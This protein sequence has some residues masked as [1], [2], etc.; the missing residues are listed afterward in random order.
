[1]LNQIANQ[2]RRPVYRFADGGF[3]TGPVVGPGALPD[4]Y[5]IPGGTKSEGYSRDYTPDERIGI[6]KAFIRSQEDASYGPQG[7]MADMEKYGISAKDIALSHGMGEHGVDQYL[8]RSGATPEFGG[9]NTDWDTQKQDE[10]IAWQNSQP[11]QFGTGTMGDVFK[12]QGVSDNDPVRRAQAQEIIERQAARA[13]MRSGFTL[14]GGVTAPDPVPGG[15]GGGGTTPPPGGGGTPPGPGPGQPP[16]F[17][18][19]PVYQ[20]PAPFTGPNGTIYPNSI[21]T[22]QGP[23]PTYF[24][25]SWWTSSPSASK[26]YGQTTPSTARNFEAEMAEYRKKYAPVLTQPTPPGPI[27]APAAP[28][29]PAPDPTKPPT[30]NPGAG[31]EWVWDGAAWVAKPVTV[32]AARGGEVNKLWN[33]YHGR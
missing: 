32:N 13:A 8:V 2:Y 7:L 1:M 12:K 22:P 29:P 23:Q 31:M 10:F 14:S 9:I 21:Q 11:N 18:P 17:T 27:P 24:P 33:K 30:E 19:P 20:P 6:N 25:T 15:G 28:T 4:G 16:P 3:V 26:A 5:K